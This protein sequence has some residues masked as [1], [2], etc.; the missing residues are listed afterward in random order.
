MRFFDPNDELL[1]TQRK[2]PHWAQ[3]GAV[4]Q[5]KL[6]L[7]NIE[8]GTEDNFESS[9]TADA[10]WFAG[11]DNLTNRTKRPKAPFSALSIAGRASWSGTV[12]FYFLKQTGTY[13]M[14]VGAFGMCGFL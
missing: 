14:S 10:A 7:K 8:T 9:Y 13:M 1:I 5:L 2:L 4:V 3:D 12:L 6:R 11:N